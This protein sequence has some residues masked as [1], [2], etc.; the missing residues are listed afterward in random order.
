AFPDEEQTGE[1]CHFKSSTAMDFKFAQLYQ[2]LDAKIKLRNLSY[3]FKK[4]EKN[5]L[6]LTWTVLGLRKWL[7]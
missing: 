7:F 6:R 1:V 3:Y 4:N 5:R 2:G